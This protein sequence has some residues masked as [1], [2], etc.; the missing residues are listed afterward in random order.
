MEVFFETQIEARTG[1][2]MGYDGSW[3][4]DEIMTRE[5]EV[6]VSVW[7]DPNE[8]HISDIEVK[9]IDE[10][11]DVDTRELDYGTIAHLKDEAI[12]RYREMVTE[13][14][15]ANARRAR[16]EEAF[17]RSKK[18]FAGPRHFAKEAV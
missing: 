13:I 16:I 9:I 6:T 17:K 15:A 3:E 7:E 2:K 10:L 5:V 11:P 1:T 14:K 18:A 8:Y 12:K 4:T